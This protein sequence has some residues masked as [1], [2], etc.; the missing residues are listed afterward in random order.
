MNAPPKFSISGALSAKIASLPAAMTVEAA[1]RVAI[2]VREALLKTMN[3]QTAP[4]GERWAP[5]KRGT[6]PVLVN[7]SDAL[8]VGS[9]GSTVIIA[10]HGIE[11]R[12]HRGW[13]KGGTARPIIID[14]H[15]GMTAPVAA[16]IHA[17]LDTAFTEWKVT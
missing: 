14:K 11:A 17:A 2:A 3:A 9:S 12:H 16:A 10:L 8:E 6:R 1:P 7:A 4:D 15:T 13:V 5:R